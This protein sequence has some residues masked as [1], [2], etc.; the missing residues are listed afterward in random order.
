MVFHMAVEVTDTEKLNRLLLPG[1]M[2][3]QRLPFA[4][5]IISSSD[6]LLAV[7]PKQDSLWPG[8]HPAIS[9]FHVVGSG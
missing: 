8:Q 9:G 5:V 2:C 4:L 1:W 6:H 7:G 3:L